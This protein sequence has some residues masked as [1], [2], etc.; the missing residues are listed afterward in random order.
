[1]IKI[2]NT[3]Q[4]K[5][6]DSATIANE[7][8]AS[9]DLME[10][11]SRAFVNWFVQ[12]F[13]ASKKIG[14]VC[15]TG[16][17]GG[18]GLAIARLL[19]DWGFPVKVWIVKGLVPHSEDFKIN[20]ERINGKIEIFEIFKESDRTLFNDRDVLIDAIFG[21][22]LSR[23]VEGIYAQAIRC[24]NNSSA[25]RIAVDIPSGL[26]ADSN[27]DG[28]IVRADF[29]F[30]FQI[31][32]L[33]FF[34]PQS[35]QFTGEW[36]VGDI[37]LS[38]KFVSETT[39]KHFLVT[40]KDVRKILRPRNR[41]DHKGQFGHALIVAGSYGKMGAAILASKAAL[42]S[43]LGLLTCH[44]PKSGYGIMQIAVP[45]AMISVDPDE[46]FV[47]NLDA[48]EKYTTIGIGPGIGQAAA[49]KNGLK[50]LLEVFKKPMVLDA[51]ALNILS[52]DQSLIAE[53]PEGS[54]LTPH[55]KEFE[56]L[57]GKWGNDFERLG[58]QKDFSMKYKCVVVLKGAYT[59]TS[60]ADGNVYFNPTGTPAM[61]K[62][63]SGDVL[64]GILT[65]MLSQSYA[66]IE[67]AILGVY[68]H[69]LCG[70]LGAV[71]KSVYSLTA[72]DLTEILPAAF[73]SLKN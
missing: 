37:A 55:P 70:N 60:D 54:I 19:K 12:K 48:V 71:D 28:E 16:N 1:M 63:G 14:I 31:P 11:A 67:S 33:S 53:I 21:S 29:T 62:G 65:A 47:T 39:S 64:T 7:P 18:D 20:F 45:E 27:M 32:K 66:P 42:R 40:E 2:L 17:N 34:F 58:K 6:W 51:D 30:S 4:I 57:V 61:A 3:K 41:F 13:D 36:V 56:R 24:I 59:S 5:D 69:G 15:A 49:T 23:P 73:K 35:Y 38:K 68:L 52:N 26:S 46:N 8:I 43:G 72:S 22:G 44:V 25:C 9:I 50:K 10:R